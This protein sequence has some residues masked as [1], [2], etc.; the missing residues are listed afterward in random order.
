MARALLDAFEQTGESRHLDLAVETMEYVLAD[1]STSAGAF[2]DVAATEGRERGPLGLGLP[3]VP[4]QDA[5]TPSGNGTAILALD[6]LAALT[7]E[8][9]YRDAAERALR[10][11]AP[12]NAAHGLHAATLTLALDMHLDPPLH[13]V[14][15]GPGSDPRTRRLHDAALETYRPGTIVHAYDPSRL[16]G[17]RAGAL[18]APMGS[19]ATDRSEPRAYACTA[20]A[21][22]APAGDPDALRETIR[23][24]GRVSA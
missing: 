8:S 21:C 23:A 1:F 16:D 14:V 6:R 2:Y 9:R 19:A 15:V 3:Y 20:T 11:S 13:V 24:F 10:A 7:G 12:G 18:P 22:A 17:A 4:V 5:P